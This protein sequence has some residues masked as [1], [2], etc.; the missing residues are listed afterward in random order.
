LYIHQG[1]HA[2]KTPFYLSR[3][4]STQAELSAHLSNS[5]KTKKALAAKAIPGKRL[6][7]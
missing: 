6:S 2:D 1:F 4:F 7:I 3:I 5:A